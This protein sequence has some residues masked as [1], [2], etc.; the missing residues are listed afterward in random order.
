MSSTSY[1]FSVAHERWRVIG[2]LEL[3][4]LGLLVVLVGWL[5]FPRDL[6]SGLRAARMDAV[7]LSYAQTWLRAEPDDYDLRLL[8]ARDLIE[9]G[10][11][12]QAR[13]QLDYLADHARQPDLLNAQA[14]LRSRLPF[15]A[16]MG[17]PPEERAS[18]AL[19]QQ[20]VVAFRQ[21]DPAGLDNE[22][23]LRYADMALLLGDLDAAV[24]A[25]HLLAARQ[26][27]PSAWY[28]QAARS[29]L[30]QGRYQ[31]AADEYLRAMENQTD[32]AL[33]RADFLRALTTLQAG[34]LLDQAL[35]VGGRLGPEFYH[36]PAVLYRLMTLARAAGDH[37]QAQFYAGRLLR[38]DG[39]HGG[40]G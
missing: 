10:L 9:L 27:S 6:S 28:R 15:V 31:A 32:P 2:P 25:Y 18:S 33:R 17:L 26:P 4:V 37:G 12:G 19:Q 29:L 8:M 30:A 23:V 36:Q 35:A 38:L 14:W 20:A 1:G 5:V 11:F 16:L 22:D 7:T 21:V 24:R 40:D 39:A 13:E 3:L 34:G